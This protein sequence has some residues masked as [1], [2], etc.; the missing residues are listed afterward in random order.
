MKYVDK[1]HSLDKQKGTPVSELIQYYIEM[2]CCNDG[3]LSECSYGA[4]YVQ[5]RTRF[6]S[7]EKEMD[8]NDKLSYL[9]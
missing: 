3:G 9:F 7:W 4:S 1:W 5:F 6:L 2:F 8:Y